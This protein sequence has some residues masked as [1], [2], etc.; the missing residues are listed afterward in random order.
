MGDAVPPQRG[1]APAAVGKVPGPPPA[2][3]EPRND[4]RNGRA[5]GIALHPRRRAPV[6]CTGSGSPQ[7]PRRG[8]GTRPAAGTGTTG[9]PPR[10]HGSPQD[11]PA[12]ETLLRSVGAGGRPGN[13]PG[14]E[15]DRCRG[16]A[17][18]LL[19]LL[20]EERNRPREN[21]PGAD[22]HRERRRTGGRLFSV[23]PLARSGGPGRN[24]RGARPLQ[25]PPVGTHGP[26]RGGSKEAPGQLRGLRGA[27]LC[28]PPAGRGVP[29]P[30]RRAIRQGGTGRAV[31]ETQPDRPRVRRARAEQRSGGNAHRGARPRED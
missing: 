26:G 5:R 11:R 13:R 20:V 6:L 12:A 21:D 31:L 28:D 4:Q 18:R 24:G 17:L 29:E 19:G 1:R 23:A 2:E 22:R 14:G 27:R 10:A 16:V 8:A 15:I 25:G 3:G 30:R 7:F 9:V